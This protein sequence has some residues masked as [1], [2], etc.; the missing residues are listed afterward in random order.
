MCDR[1]G[2]DTIHQCLFT[3]GSK[4]RFIGNKVAE[5][6]VMVINEANDDGRARD[7]NGF[8]D[9]GPSIWSLCRRCLV[10]CLLLSALN[11]GRSRI[12]GHTFCHVIES[13]PKN[14][15]DMDK[16]ILTLVLLS[17]HALNGLDADSCEGKSAFFFVGKSPFFSSP[18]S[19]DSRYSYFSGG[20]RSHQFY[21]LKMLKG[22]IY[23]LLST[24]GNKMTRFPSINKGCHCPAVIWRKNYC[25]FT[26]LVI[27]R[28]LLDM[29]LFQKVKRI[30]RSFVCLLCGFIQ[31]LL[32]SASVW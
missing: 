12:V 17:A 18:S 8:F 19:P 32:G 25:L 24:Q 31:F 27:G 26:S 15:E 28:K 23:L 22:R 20:S 1:F 29:S 4:R 30:S 14:W 2:S 10:D 3:S 16:L 13:P 5:P 21:G 7:E 9:Q 11:E 6:S